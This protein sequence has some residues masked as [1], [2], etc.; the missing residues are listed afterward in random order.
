MTNETIPPQGPEALP[1]LLKGAVDVIE[2][3]D[4]EAK[5][6]RAARSG[7]PLTV[8]AGFDPS[9]PD[10]HLG[11]TVLLR[12]LKHFQDAGHRVVFLIGDFTA[13]IGDPSGKK[14]TRP[15]LSR[16]QVA[17]NAQTFAEQAFHVLDR[18]RTVID[19]NG[20]WLD[21]LG[22]DGF[23]RLAG[24]YTVARI[25]EREDFRKRLASGQPVFMH[26]LLY[27]LVQGYDSVALGADVE[28]GG[29]D[30]LFN[31]LVGRDL[32]RE[33]G[34]EPQVVLTMPLLEGTD[35]VEKM[36]KSL[37][38]AIGVT[39]PPAEMYG[40]LMSISDAL[41]WRYWELLTDE[42]TEAVAAMKNA[43]AAGTLHPKQAKSRLAIRIT[44]DFHGA[45][46]AEEEAAVFDR[47]FSKGE[48]PA[49][50]PV[51]PYPLAAPAVKPSQVIAK[52]ASLSTSEA[53]RLIEQKAVKI[54]SPE[55]GEL[56]DIA[57]DRPEPRS[58]GESV[59]YKVGKLRW[60]TVKFEAE[61]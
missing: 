23:I 8:K 27:P 16:E 22:A 35:G 45:K 56:V 54:V 36:S 19:Y 10:I 9:A 34:Q 52:A 2:K 55:S 58:P 14:A 44:G 60:V 15:Q 17:E 30:Q 18:S 57:A 21:E 59:T 50:I 4:L 39:D 48:I 11:H 49:E 13:R 53:R 37:G 31:L 5:L 38:N 12:K 7:K 51:F 41:M 32:Q 29:T 20:R 43:V 46:A 24:K 40:K 3:K 33:W 6:A 61:P 25:I 42:T 28:L 47:R 1:Q 26:E